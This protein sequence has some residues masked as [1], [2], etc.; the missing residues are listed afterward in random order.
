MPGW[1]S[2]NKIDNAT[3]AHEIRITRA[4]A[5]TTTMNKYQARTHV[6]DFFL[7]ARVTNLL[8]VSKV[9]TIEELEGKKGLR[10]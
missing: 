7:S 6:C 1:C 2:G 10:W 4:A 5:T 3:P 9:H 8:W